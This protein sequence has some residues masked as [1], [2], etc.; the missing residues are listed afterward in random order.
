E[1]VK[2]CLAEE[3]K[4]IDI[5]SLINKEDADLEKIMADFVKEVEDFEAGPSSLST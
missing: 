5:T 1:D 3:R 4:T 2:R